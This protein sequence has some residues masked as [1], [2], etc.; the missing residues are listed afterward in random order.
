MAQALSCVRA[1]LR[2]DSSSLSG[3]ATDRAARR[4][5]AALSSLMARLHHDSV[6]VRVFLESQR[7]GPPVGGRPHSA[8]SPRW[9][10]GGVSVP[11]PRRV[12]IR[13]GETRPR[14]RRRRARA[15]PGR[16]H[17]ASRRAAGTTVGGYQR[18]LRLTLT[19][20]S[21]GLGSQAATVSLGARAR[22]RG[23][24]ECQCHVQTG[25]GGKTEMP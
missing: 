8:P 3:I 5:P 22:R 23:R 16:R 7:I 13:V 9:P 11:A 18:Q 17:G 2:H 19:L 20:M 4:R 14:S 6:I 24:S 15:A 12:R 1:R 21:D 10:G 25:T